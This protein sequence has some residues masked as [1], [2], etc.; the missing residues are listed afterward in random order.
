[1]TS[2]LIIRRSWRVF[3]FAALHAREAGLRPDPELLYLSAI[4]TTSVC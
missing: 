3:F 2:P 1:M 4:S